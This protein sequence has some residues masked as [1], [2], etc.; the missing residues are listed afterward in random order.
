MQIVGKIWTNYISYKIQLTFIDNVTVENSEEKRELTDYSQYKKGYLSVDNKQHSMTT[1]TGDTT[2]ITDN[3]NNN[4]H[5]NNKEIHILNETETMLSSDKLTTDSDDDEDDDDDDDDKSET[6]FMDDDEHQATM[7]KLYNPK[8]RINKNKQYTKQDIYNRNTDKSISPDLLRMSNTSTQPPSFNVSK[9]MP[10][11]RPHIVDNNETESRLSTSFNFINNNHNKNNDEVDTISDKFGN[12]F[13]DD[14]Y[15][16]YY[17]NNEIKTDNLK[18]KK[19]KKR[20]RKKSKNKFGKNK[21]ESIDMDINT[22]KDSLPSSSQTSR[23]NNSKTAKYREYR[24][25]DPIDIVEGFSNS[26]KEKQKSITIS[27][28]NSDCNHSRNNSF[29]NINNLSNINNNNQS[30]ITPMIGTQEFENESNDKNGNEI[31]NISENDK[32]NKNEGCDDIINIPM[33]S[34]NN[35]SSIHHERDK[36]VE[37]NPMNGSSLMRPV[38]IIRR[39]IGIQNEENLENQKHQIMNTKKTTTNKNVNGPTLSHLFTI[40]PEPRYLSISISDSEQKLQEATSSIDHGHN[41]IIQ[42]KEKKYMMRNNQISTNY[43]RFH[44]LKNSI[45]P[46]PELIPQP[47]ASQIE[48]GNDN[49]NN[50]ESFYVALNDDNEYNK[51]RP[52]PTPFAK[53][54]KLKRSHSNNKNIDQ[55]QTQKVITTKTIIRLKNSDNNNKNNK[56]RKTQKKSVDIIH[57]KKKTKNIKKVRYSDH[58]IEKVYTPDS[59]I[60]NKFDFNANSTPNMLRAKSLN[61][62]INNDDDDNNNNNINN[63]YTKRNHYYNNA[64]K[65]NYNHYVSQYE[66]Q[67]H[68]PSKHSSSKYS[69]SKHSSSKHSSSSSKHSSSHHSSS[70]NNHRG[71]IRD[72]DYYRNSN[73]P[74]Y[75][76]R[77]SNKSQKSLSKRSE[78]PT[79]ISS[80]QFTF[81]TNHNH[82]NNDHDQDDQD[83]DDDDDDD[84][85]DDYSQYTQ[86]TNKSDAKYLEN[87]IDHFWRV[88]DIASNKK[89]PFEILKISLRVKSINI[90]ENNWDILLNELTN[91]QPSKNITLKMFKDFIFDRKSNNS[92]YYR[93][94]QIVNRLRKKLIVGL[95]STDDRSYHHRQKQRQQK[96]QRY[97]KHQRQQRQHHHQKQQRFNNHNYHKQRQKHQHPKLSNKHSSRSRS[98]KSRSKSKTKSTSK[99]RKYRKHS[100]DDN[101]IDNGDN[102]DF[103]DNYNNNNNQ[104]YNDQYNDEYNDEYNDDDDTKMKT[105]KFNIIPANNEKRNGKLSKIPRIPKPRTHKKHQRSFSGYDENQSV[106]TMEQFGGKKFIDENNNNN[107]NNNKYIGRARSSSYHSYLQCS[108]LSR[109]NSTMYNESS[110]MNSSIMNGDNNSNN[111]HNNNNN[112]IDDKQFLKYTIQQSLIMSLLDCYDNS[113]LHKINGS[114]FMSYLNHNEWRKALKYL[115]RCH[116]AYISD[117]EDVF[118]LS[119]FKFALYDQCNIRFDFNYDND[120]L[121]VLS[122][123]DSNNCKQYVITEHSFVEWMLKHIDQ[124]INIR[125]KQKLQFRD[126]YL[127]KLLTIVC[128]KKSQQNNNNRKKIKRKNNNHNHLTTNNMDNPFIAISPSQRINHDDNNHLNYNHIDYNNN[129]NNNKRELQLKLSKA[130]SLNQMKYVN[131][132]YDT[133]TTQQTDSTLDTSNNNIDDNNND[134]NNHNN[135]NN[136][137]INH[138]LNVNLSSSRNRHHYS[139]SHGTSPIDLTT[140]STAATNGKQ[141]HSNLKYRNR[142]NG[143]PPNHK[144]MYQYK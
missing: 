111:I 110:M 52:Q 127:E 3:I 18:N 29:P 91:F 81:N 97:Q 71:R 100:Y 113:L 16:D 132:N 84:D 88:I 114:R 60:D 102:N 25:K 94:N 116:F 141:F 74:S 117:N 9:T 123:N 48:K 11:E 90:R 33:T 7:L 12:G 8:L 26:N 13:I 96:Q 4:K 120:I 47:R 40:E 24:K 93:D 2:T 85:D 138:H 5:R 23:N 20:K 124:I 131:P 39:V 104:N 135:N 115:L 79:N 41:S 101:N 103:N 119:K 53:K 56:Q 108:S 139:I 78:T 64:P 30:P 72:N 58:N 130:K 51:Y 10:Q 129:N 98:K 134:N 144:Y 17:D 32:K 44:F 70:N 38:P 75:K 80:E 62:S 61:P 6:E 125:Q 122:F 83:E 49:N 15:N 19:S 54:K 118:P 66:Y 57:T 63:H 142:Q 45:K 67:R 21:N 27:R 112:D 137:N 76:S 36:S 109:T 143:P 87:T 82:Y 77:K 121:P 107:N 55:S 68:V 43:S 31:E 133:P 28:T 89:I 42:E 106:D 73:I 14:D 128:Y 95:L 37:V 99:S 22:E 1:D 92:H 86:I 105:I 136:N 65:H 34:I 46:G 69:S 35:K 50:K 59:Y 140:T 126:R